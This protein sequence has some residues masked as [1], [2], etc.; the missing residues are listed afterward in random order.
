[1]SSAQAQGWRAGCCRAY[2]ALQSGSGIS[3]GAD[4]TH[5]LDFWI[6]ESRVEGYPLLFLAMLVFLGDDNPCFVT[7]CTPAGV[8]PLV[9]G[10]V[11]DA[12]FDAAAAVVLPEYMDAL[13]A[14]GS[15]GVAFYPTED[16]WFG[17]S[18]DQEMRSVSAGDALFVNDIRFMIDGASPADKLICVEASLIDWRSLYLGPAA[19]L[20]AVCECHCE[21]Q[22]SV[23]KT[24]V[25]L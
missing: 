22:H 1:M 9:R 19:A 21:C 11:P 4:W 10:A 3:T 24:H 25:L 15:C 6:E 5:L 2:E 17:Y 12:E 13:L 20:A 16:G 23:T 7:N 18:M 14:E 8:A